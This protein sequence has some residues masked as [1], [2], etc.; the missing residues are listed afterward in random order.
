MK[1]N[2][3]LF[4]DTKHQCI[5]RVSKHTVYMKTRSVCV[6][7]WWVFRMQS[8]TYQSHFKWDLLQLSQRVQCEWDC[9]LHPVTSSSYPA[10]CGTSCKQKQVWEGARDTTSSAAGWLSLTPNTKSSKW[11]YTRAKKN[12]N[13]CSDSYLKLYISFGVVQC[14]LDGFCS[15]PV[16]CIMESP[17]GCAQ[18]TSLCRLPRQI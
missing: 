17:R 8:T 10:C 6:F 4:S 15:G 16:G 12:W 13:V 11:T 5:E 14:V 18:L 9:W 7:N 2:E 3:G 1:Q